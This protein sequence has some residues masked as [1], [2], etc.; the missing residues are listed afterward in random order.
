MFTM[1]TLID[2]DILDIK[3]K[4]NFLSN[5]PNDGMFKTAHFTRTMALQ[6][7]RCIIT[8]ESEVS[9]NNGKDIH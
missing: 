3:L 9:C 4:A 7:G 6:Y 8:A 2:E 5:F 1:N